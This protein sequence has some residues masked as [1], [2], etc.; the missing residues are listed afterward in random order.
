MTVVPDRDLDAVQFFES[1]VPVW[2]ATPAA[3]GL[4]AAQVAALDTATKAARN[5]YTAQQNARNAAKAATTA[6]HNNVGTM[7]EIGGDLIKTIKAFAATSNNPGV[8]AAAQI[9]MPAQPG[10][11]PPPG[12]PDDF[13][14]RL[15]GS[16]GLSLNWKAANA[17]PS[18]GAYF[19]V[20]RRL[21][22]Q[23]PFVFIG[24]TGGKTFVDDS[25]PAGTSFVTYLVQGFRGEQPGPESELVSVQFGAG[26]NVN[27]QFKLAA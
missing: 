17:A 3:V 9:P 24:G 13:D 18:T 4:T 5:A 7:R 8:Y 20:R 10:P 16:G 1:H 6:Y 22:S 2:A 12:Q 25:I 14:V 26:D 15:T 19:T 23:G 21:G 11:L 27:A